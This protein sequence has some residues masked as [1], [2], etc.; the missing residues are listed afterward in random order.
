MQDE[1]E[2]D[3]LS[4]IINDINEF[5]GKLPEGTEENS[6]K[7]IDSIVSDK[8][9]QN[10]INSDNTESN[11]KDKLKEIYETKNIKT[12][13]TSSKLYDFFEKK[14]FKDKLIRMFISRPDMIQSILKGN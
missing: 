2:F 7:L 13:E 14:E 8:D 9:F 5:Y 6:K 10:V 4:E 11:K 3:L 12:L 1:E